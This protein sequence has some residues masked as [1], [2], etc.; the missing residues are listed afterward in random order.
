MLSDNFELLFLVLLIIAL[1]GG[2]LIVKRLAA[3]ESEV[4]ELKLQLALKKVADYQSGEQNIQVVSDLE[5]PPNKDAEL[6]AQLWQPKEEQRLTIFNRLATDLKIIL[7]KVSSNGLLWLGGFVLALGGVFLAKYAIEAE[8]ISAQARVILGFI[9]GALLLIAAEYLMRYPERFNIQSTQI[10]AALASAGIITCFSMMVVSTHYYAFIAPTPALFATLLVTSI[11]TFMSL[12]F[13]PIVA[14]IGVIGSYAVPA[15]FWSNQLT[16]LELCL[17]VIFISSSAIY[18]NSKVDNKYLWYLSFVAN[19]IYLFVTIFISHSTT[20]VSVLVA[21]SLA[22]L[23]LYTLSP[24]LGWNLRGNN[25]KPLSLKVLLMPRKEQAGVLC[26]IPPIWVYYGIFGFE[27]ELV[28][29]NL[30]FTL[31]LFWAAYRHSAFD[32]WPI[33]A[34]LLNLATLALQ[35][36]STNVDDT[37]FMYTG[38]HLFTQVSALIF[39]SYALFSHYKHPRRPAYSLLLGLSIPL[40]FAVTYILT[41]GVISEALYPLWTVELAIYGFIAVLICNRYKQPHIQVSGWLLANANLT[42]IFTLL[43]E[44]GTLTLALTA[45][46]VSLAYWS[47]RFKFSAPNWLIQ[48][49][50]LVVLLRL[51]CAPWISHYSNETLSG[52]H[53][54]LIIYPACLALLYVASSLFARPSLEPWL[55]GARMHLVALFVT[56]ES[57]YFLIGDYPSLINISFPEVVILGLNYMALGCVYLYRARLSQHALVSQLYNLFGYALLLSCAVLH[58]I[59]LIRFNPL[60]TNQDLGE[61]FLLNWIAPMWLLP[62]IILLTGLRFRLFQAELLLTIKLIISALIVFTINSTIRHFYHNG[63][64]GIDF[65]LQETELYTY[66]VVWLVIAAATIVWS[67]IHASRLAHQ[68]GFGLMFVVISKAFV[69]D[70]SELTGLLRAFSF[71]GLGLCLVAIGWLFQRLRH[72]K[73]DL[74]HS[75]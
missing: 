56:T 48:T 69:I 33:L 57:S 17:F 23:Y 52:F 5:T 62:A 27:S 4:E 66:S 55:A 73:Q 53:W 8:L 31:V 35:I 46:L 44:A 67:Q 38:T 37:L 50:V 32:T 24:I 43:L 49:V 22:S 30:V 71:L 9:V 59:L 1:F 54:T 25:P 12:R 29:Y 34:L 19:F 45:Q 70:M 61:T 68:I 36:P 63:Y 26:A 3:L 42:L 60:F 20:D 14:F 40:L 75:S 21:F 41:P 72:D 51:T 47:R 58:A 15:L 18:I 13:G 16:L 39:F 10:S 28:V 65:G 11:A 64:I 74:T 2:R 7:D 6:E